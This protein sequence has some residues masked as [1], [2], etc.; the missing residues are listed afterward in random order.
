MALI[1]CPECGK[2]VSDKAMQ[3]IHCGYPLSDI[4][5]TVT[6]TPESDEIYKAILVSYNDDAKS[7]TVR[8]IREVTYISVEEANEL[9]E[10]CP[11]CIVGEITDK[12]FERIKQSFA[13][14]GAVVQRE[15]MGENDTVYALSSSMRMQSNHPPKMKSCPTCKKSISYNAE[16]CPHCGHSFASEERK[17]GLGFWGIVGAVIVAIIIMAFL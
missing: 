4:A 17:S 7:D 3:C 9:V 14:V 11:S 1:K 2:E 13:D 6:D 12:E 10:N 16:S 5:N 8:V 15:E